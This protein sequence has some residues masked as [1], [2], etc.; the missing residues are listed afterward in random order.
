M[1]G[2]GRTCSAADASLP[3]NVPKTSNAWLWSLSSGFDAAEGRDGAAPR[4]PSLAASD[5]SVSSSACPSAA[6]PLL[7]RFPL[8]DFSSS[9]FEAASLRVLS[10]CRGAPGTC[11]SFHDLE[12]NYIAHRNRDR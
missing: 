9:N 10:A 11:S 1:I 12:C 2:T 3:I 4:A 8:D 7:L 6:F 5:T